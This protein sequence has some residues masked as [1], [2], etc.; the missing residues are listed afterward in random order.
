MPGECNGKML[1]HIAV[2]DDNKKADVK[3]ALMGEFS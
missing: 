1:L 2:I 3:K